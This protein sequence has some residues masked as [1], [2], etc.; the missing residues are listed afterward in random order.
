MRLERIV[1]ISMSCGI[2]PAGNKIKKEECHNLLMYYVFFYDIVEI[3]S[4]RSFEGDLKCQSKQ[5]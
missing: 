1:H 3:N 5:L 2:F 4:E